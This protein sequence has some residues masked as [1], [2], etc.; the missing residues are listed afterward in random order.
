MAFSKHV[1]STTRR[2]FLKGAGLA[3][4]AALTGG[5]PIP[6]IAQAQEINIISAESNA[7]ALAALKKIA[8]DFGKQAGT[9]VVVNNMDHEAHKTAIRNYL[10]AGAPDVCTWFSGN[11]MRAFVKRG[12]FDDIS[13]LFEKE[14][15][16][17]V[18]GATTG[19]VTV[20]GKQYGLPTGGTLWG[21]FYRKDVFDQNGLS[22]PT[23]AEEFSAYCDKAKA[24]GLTPIAMGTKELWPAAG[25]FDQM[26]LRINGLDKHMA[27]MDGQMSY[28]DP[29][30]TGVFDQWEAMIKKEVF[31]PNHTS[32]GWQEAAALLAQKKAGMMNLG[33]FLRAAFTEA[34]LPQLSFAPFPVLDPSVARYE[35]FSVNSIHIPAN[36]K[37]KQGA[38]EFLTYFYKPDNL[39]AY[40][41]PGGNVPPR[42]DLPPSKDPLVNAAV[43]SLKQVKGTSQYYDRDSDP[44]MA[45]AGLVG[46]QEFMVK[47]ERRQAILQRLEGTRKRIY[48]I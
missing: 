4:A 42:N 35:E 29:A 5:F 31:T 26:N 9:T 14:K 6:A 2:T 13:D 34:D 18:L 7:K 48:K 11:R 40:L 25:W 47:P 28:L 32:F 22:V 3:S 19:A 10:V 20:D 24:A 38:R 33:A 27:L 43:E 44:D 15:Y 37:N 23:T 39:A 12:L 21:M 41:E 16:K 1:S 30:L 8:E 17:D 36:A 46:F 45:Q